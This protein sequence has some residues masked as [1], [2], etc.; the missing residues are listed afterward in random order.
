[1]NVVRP[2]YFSTEFWLSLAS[3]L[4]GALLASGLF[5]SEGVWAQVAGAVVVVLN[6]LGYTVTRGQ[7]K[8]AVVPVALPPPRLGE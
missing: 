7:L 8:R 2:G 1:M 3:L 4:V 6:S 5:P